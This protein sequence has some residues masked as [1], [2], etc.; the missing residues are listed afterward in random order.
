SVALA[1]HGTGN[2]HTGEA[3]MW[4]SHTDASKYLQRVE[5]WALRNP[6]YLG[7]LVAIGWLLGRTTAQRVI[8]ITLLVL[9]GPAYS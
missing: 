3:P 1:P 5:R 2:L 9:I 6:G 8:Y 4:K 7:I